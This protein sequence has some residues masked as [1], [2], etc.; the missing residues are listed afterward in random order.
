MRIMIVDDHEISRAVCRALLR[1]EGADVVADLGASD[2]ALAAARALR[3]QVVIVDVTPATG[4]GLGIARA[5]RRL[6]APP[7]VILTSS[8]DRARFG[9]EVNGYRFV[10]KADI[11]AT[12][13]AT[14]ASA[15]ERAGPGATRKR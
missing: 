13:I 10:G 9:P 15:P 5:L 4:S 8:A 3:P 2:D 14:L 12:V 7:T 6:P 1:A 11:S